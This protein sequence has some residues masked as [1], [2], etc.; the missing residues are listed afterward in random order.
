MNGAV[1]PGRVFLGSC[2][3]LVSTSVCFA[4]V[5]AIMGALKAQF[6][7]SNEQAGWIGGAAIWGF[8]VSIIVLGPLCNVLGMGNLLRFAMLC[9]FAG[10]L[11]MIFANG[12]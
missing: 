3:S 1:H 8:T 6:L 2:L 12:F 4:A 7:L 10:P 5:G 9:H 11:L